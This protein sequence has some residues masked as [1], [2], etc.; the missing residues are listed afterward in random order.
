MTQKSETRAV[1]ARASR[2]SCGGCFRDPLSPLASSQQA[3]PELIAL[4]LGESFVF[5]LADGGEHD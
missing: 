4:H 1:E 5:G 2:N 3:V